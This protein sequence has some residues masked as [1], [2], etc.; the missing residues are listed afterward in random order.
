MR[1]NRSKAP[2]LLFGLEVV[3]LARANSEQGGKPRFSTGPTN[4]KVE[5]VRGRATTGGGLRD[6]KSA[7]VRLHDR[8][9]ISNGRP[10][11][12]LP[13]ISPQAIPLATS[14]RDII[15]PASVGIVK[16]SYGALVGFILCVLVPTLIA[17]VYYGFIASN[18]YETEFRFAVK[19]TTPGA[20]PAVSNLVALAGNI[21]GPNIF[22]NYLVT[23][24]LTSREAIEQLQQRINVISFYT[25]D[26]IDWWSRFDVSQPMEKF[27]AYWQKMVT[28]RYDPVTG[29]AT[30]TVRAFS[31]QD[32]MLISET[33][34]TLSEE[35]VNRIANR[36]QLDAVR[37]AQREVDR[38]EERLKAVR[39][40][41]TE[42]RNRTGVIDPTNSIVASNAT[43]IQTL[44]ANL[45]QLET[46]LSTL[47]RQNLDPTAPVITVLKNQ[48]KST[49]E[50]LETIE[51]TVGTDRDGKP[52]SMVMGEYEQ[53]DLERQFAQNM[54]ISTMQALAQARAQAASQFLYITPY[55]RPAL[56][57]S[58]THPRRTLSIAMVGIG[59]F[60]FWLIGLLIVRSIRERFA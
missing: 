35:L 21:N 44:R 58:S 26:E 1:G 46:Q 40:Q 52:L 14:S 56:P 16:K 59:A 25:K 53:L 3:P 10:K 41:M 23:D 33:L 45:A 42:Y 30:A 51:A 28:A 13:I 31:P 24:F 7:V 50:Q 8:R 38:A 36:T 6:Q 4:A 22:D 37:F 57:Q 54:V 19:D 29:I 39:A 55:V 47:L 11:Q 2:H 18:Q 32:A 27:V 9:T 17:T 12:Y 15:P 5:H 20:N 34:I 48:I 60:A 43:L 49:K